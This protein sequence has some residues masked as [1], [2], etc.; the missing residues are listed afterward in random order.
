MHNTA[1]VTITGRVHSSMVVFCGCEEEGVTLIRLGFWPAT[2]CKP[3]TG[4]ALD[5][6]ALLYNLT[7]ECHISAKSFVQTMRWKNNLSAS[8][9]ISL[10]NQ[11]KKYR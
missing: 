5:L 1:V 9:V 7:V 3:S 6:M 8:E 2:V 4:F 10:N 11:I